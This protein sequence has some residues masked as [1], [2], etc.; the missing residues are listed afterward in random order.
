MDKISKDV[1]Q[2][3]LVSLV[4]EEVEQYEKEQLWIQL[5]YILKQVLVELI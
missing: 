5:M 4:T 3:Q 2:K 1:A